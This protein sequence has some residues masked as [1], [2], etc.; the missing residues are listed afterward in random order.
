MD[1]PR[2]GRFSVTSYSPHEIELWKIEQS[3]P[4]PKSARKDST[5][6]ATPAPRVLKSE[7]KEA[8]LRTS[9]SRG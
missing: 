3:S 7:E 5:K 1:N 9:C 4:N 6:A 2:P 8:V